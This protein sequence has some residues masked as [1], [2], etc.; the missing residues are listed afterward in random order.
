MGRPTKEKKPRENALT[1]RELIVALAALKDPSA[2]VTFVYGGE[3]LPVKVV[4]A[5]TT[6]HVFLMHVEGPEA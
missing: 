2:R 3:R 5:D 4:T 1:A 6:G